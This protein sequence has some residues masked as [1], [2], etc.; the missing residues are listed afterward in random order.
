MQLDLKKIK[1]HFQKSIDDYTENAVVQRLM[2]QKLT[3]LLS[4]EQNFFDNILE[5]GSGAGLLTAELVRSVKF[6][7]YYANDL[8]E[9]SEQYVK[10]YVSNAKFSA[11]DFRRI[12][13]PKSYNLVAS[14]AVFQWFKNL[15]KILDFCYEILEKNGILAFST[16]SPENFKEF[17]AITG[18]T[19]PY[20]SVE[21]ITMLLDKNFKVITVQKFEHK[22]KFDNPLQILAHM[23]KTG[24]NSLSD[25]KWGI[26]EVKEFCTSYSEKFPSLELTYSPI[27]IVAR[28]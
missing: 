19:L 27:I 2:A 21:E 8:V 13:F 5:I 16:F 23:K 9:K 10:K 26:K 18:L 1:K 4:E 22:I 12:K 25:K 7:S 15:D 3:A 14:N 20:K 24:V 28:K 11:G 17:K 6:N